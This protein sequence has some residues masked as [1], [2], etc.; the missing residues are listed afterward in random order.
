ML[1]DIK[2]SGVPGI[3]MPV[4]DPIHG[5]WLGASGKADL[6]SS[7]DLKVGNITRVGSTVKTFTA[8]TILITGR[9]KAGFR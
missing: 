8:T 7:I 6:K 1:D 5:M 9:R 3:S 4:Q 2:S